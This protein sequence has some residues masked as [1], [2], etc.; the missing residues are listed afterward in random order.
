[1]GDREDH[2]LSE[3]HPDARGEH[4]AQKTG[5]RP[6]DPQSCHL[7]FTTRYIVLQYL[8]CLVSAHDCVKVATALDVADGHPIF[9]LT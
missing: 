6:C 3:G 2:L 8:S 9:T 7:K 4:P 5:L 1:M